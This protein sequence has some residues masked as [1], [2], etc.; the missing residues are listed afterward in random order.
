ME[1]IRVLLAEDHA[2]LREATAEIVNHQSDMRVVAQAGTGEEAVRLAR[3]LRPDVIVMDIAMPHLNGLE[4]TSLI[5]AECP[6]SRVLVLT[7]REEEGYIIRLLQ[8][9]ALGYLP[10][11]VALDELLEAIR[12]VARGVSVLPP[13][14]ASVV[15]RHL[16]GDAPAEPETGPLS[17]RELQVLELAAQGLTNQ[18]IAQRLYISVRTVEAHLTH[19]YN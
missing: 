10:K 12:S 6:Q 19:I 4:A 18:E 1:A 15:V 3:Q 14:I 7:A 8:A 13:E 9:G 2:V 5:T 11:T 17:S 16:A